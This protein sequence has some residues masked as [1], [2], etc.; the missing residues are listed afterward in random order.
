MLAT[1]PER[2]S[3]R[4]RKD[5]P[6]ARC[7]LGPGEDTERAR[8]TGVGVRGASS[9]ARGRLEGV[10]IAKVAKVCL[11]R[12]WERVWSPDQGPLSRVTTPGRG[13]RAGHGAGTGAELGQNP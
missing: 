2:D 7:G 4:S 9:V 13:L 11:N 6:R 5:T 12:N 3:E 1:S 8:F 10:A